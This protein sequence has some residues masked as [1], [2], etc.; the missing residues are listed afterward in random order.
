MAAVPVCCRLKN[1][2]LKTLMSPAGAAEVCGG[3]AA[4][5]AG[6]SVGRVG[7]QLQRGPKAAG[8]SG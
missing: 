5:Q 2:V 3:G 1:L 8:V 7:L 4:R 6:D